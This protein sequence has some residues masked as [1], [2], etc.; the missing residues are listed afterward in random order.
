MFM[1]ICLINNLYQPY[2]R[3]GAETVVELMAHGLRQAG[4]QVFLITTKPY[5]S[6][7]PI[8]QA[9]QDLA[10]P[11]NFQFPIFY[12]NSIFYNL[13]K[14]PE[15]IRIFWHIWDMFDL[16]SYFRVKKILKKEKPDVVITHNLKGLGYLIPRAVAGLKIKQ[17]HYLH[18]IQLIYPSGLMI[19]GQEKKINGFLA[20]IYQQICRWLFGSPHIVI[21]PS[22]WLLN[23]HEQNNFFKN[24]KKIVFKNPVAFALTD[25]TTPLPRDDSFSYKFLFV[26]Q[27]EAHK[28]VLFLLKVF[29]KFSQHQLLIAGDGS[30]AAATKKLVDKNNNIKFLGRLNHEKLME[31]LM[32]VDC[33]IVPSLCYENSPTIIRLAQKVGLPVLAADIGGISELV[34]DN[35]MLFK[36]ADEKDLLDKIDWVIKN[37]NEVKKIGIKSR[38][39]FK[40]YNLENYT[41]KLLDILLM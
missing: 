7:F 18:D 29:K 19:Y 8:S 22:H 35:R 37:N 30:L 6:K 36:P 32:A 28:G 3:G 4:H 40:N 11:D 27:I 2:N 26:G 34:K 14:T 41:N 31:I 10:K 16:I 24:S 20:G 1:K 17:V 5:F 13:S 12:I 21:S 25:L 38:E 9:T 39:E 23:F 33:L 15:F